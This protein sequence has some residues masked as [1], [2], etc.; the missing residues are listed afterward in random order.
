MLPPLTDEQLEELKADLCQWTRIVY[1]W[2]EDEKAKLGPEV[3]E[4][5]KADILRLSLILLALGK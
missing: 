1:F 2:D 5:K 4:E 3:L